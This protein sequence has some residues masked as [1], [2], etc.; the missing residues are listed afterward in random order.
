MI[1]QDVFLINSD[2]VKK[3]STVSDNM[4]EKYI[5]PC[6]VASQVQDLQQLIGTPLS[7][8]ICELYESGDI[9]EPENAVYNDL[10]TQYIQPFLLACTQSEILVSNM[11]KLRNSGN[12]QYID[13]NQTNIGI[14][15]M[16]YLKEHYSEQSAFLANR[17][18]D[19]I[20]CH[21]NEIK[22]AVFCPCC[23]G[24]GAEPKSAIKVGFVL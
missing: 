23:K 19:F 20:K 17:V 22:E 12:M 13:T 16:Q 14:K 1:L 7:V 4:E 15:D 11:A 21:R 5:N 6:I 8:R 18:T 9:E 24:L 10:L 3:F 2:Y